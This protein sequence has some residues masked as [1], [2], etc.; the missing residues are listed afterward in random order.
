MTFQRSN[1]FLILVLF[2]FACS[3]AQLIEDSSNE[4]DQSG[5]TFTFYPFGDSAFRPAVLAVPVG[6]VNRNHY[7]EYNSIYIDPAHPLNSF[8]IN[9]L[10]NDIHQFQSS[11]TTLDYNAVL[12]I[13]FR[14]NIT[15]DTALG[16]KPYKIKLNSADNVYQ[17]IND[18]NQWTEISNF[19][20]DNTA[21]TITF[22]ISDL[23]ACYVIAK[24]L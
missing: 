4:F 17:Q 7:C 23:N 2:L 19:T 21:K 14:Q 1:Y 6:A 3:K 8:E 22:E 11:A 24:R 20:F 16:F 9:F 13:P 10:I 15:F 18:V 12:T 5:K